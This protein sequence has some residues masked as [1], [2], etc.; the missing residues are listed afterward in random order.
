[1]MAKYVEGIASLVCE[2]YVQAAKDYVHAVRVGRNRRKPHEKRALAWREVAEIR[3]FFEDDP[4]GMLEDP[5]AVIER[6]E[7]IARRR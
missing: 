1:M 4:H 2:V 6:C 3:K 5:A 7:R